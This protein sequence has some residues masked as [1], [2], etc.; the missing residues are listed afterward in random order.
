VAIPALA[1]Q[2]PGDPRFTDA[3][4]RAGFVLA[5]AYV[6]GLSLLWA[7]PA[8][9]VL[10]TVFEPIGRMALTCYVSASVVA[11]AVIAL[12]GLDSLGAALALGTGTVAAQSLACRWW[13]ARF[14]YGPVEWVWRAV[15]WLS[16]PPLRR[17]REDAVSTGV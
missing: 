17:S 2:P 10:A 5:I 1:L 8:R 16:R 13:L 15:T 7:T 6:T 11:V 14:R 3:G 12:T 4:G 9:R